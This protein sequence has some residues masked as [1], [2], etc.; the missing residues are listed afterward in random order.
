MAPRLTVVISQGQSQNPAKVGMEEEIVAQLLGEPGVDVTIIPHLYDLDSEGT[1]VLCLQG[2]TGDM[3]VLGWLF[4]RAIRW[5]LDRHGVFGHEGTTLL[6]AEDE[7]EGGRRG[8]PGNPT[9]WKPSSECSIRASYRI[10]ASIASTCV[11]VLLRKHML[12][13]CGGLSRNLKPRSWN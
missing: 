4:P 13:K 7:D 12:K 1:G 3:V 2:V 5:T 9:R 6:E 10:V 8:R 11:H